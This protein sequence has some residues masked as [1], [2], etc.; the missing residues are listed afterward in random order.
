MKELSYIKTD[1][2]TS[3]P[4]TPSISPPEPLQPQQ[5]PETITTTQPPQD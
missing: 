5:V 1:I 3:V 4:S 2:E